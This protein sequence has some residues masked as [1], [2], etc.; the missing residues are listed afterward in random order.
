MGVEADPRPRAG[1]RAGASMPVARAAS[2]ARIGTRSAGSVSLR[3]AGSP[4]TTWT[5]TP[6]AARAPASSVIGRPQACASSIAARSAPRRAACGVWAA[7]T[8]SRSTGATTRSPRTRFR[9]ST[10]GTIGTTARSTSRPRP[11]D[12][13]DELRRDGRAGRVVDEDERVVVVAGAGERP[14]AG[15]HRVGSR[16]ASGDDEAAILTGRER[17][18]E[19]VDAHRRAPRSRRWRGRH[20][21]QDVEAPAPGRAAPEVLPQLVAAHPGRCDRPRRG[22]PRTR[23]PSAPAVDVTRRRSAAA[24][25]SSA[26]R[27]SGARGSR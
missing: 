13:R 25:R 12:G 8:S 15:D 10:T 22:S 4:G 1:R 17:G 16:V 9:E 24:R 27:P 14:E 26:P 18:G 11:D 20:R 19:S 23:R 21:Q 2:C 7:A 5:G 3:L 6:A